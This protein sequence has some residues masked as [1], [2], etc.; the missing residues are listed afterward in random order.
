M[1]NVSIGDHAPNKEDTLYTIQN[2]YIR[3]TTTNTKYCNKISK[4]PTLAMDNVSTGGHAP[5]NNVFLLKRTLSLQ[6]RIYMVVVT[7]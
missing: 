6:Y 4:E 3:G 2:L 7:E 5:I 1:D